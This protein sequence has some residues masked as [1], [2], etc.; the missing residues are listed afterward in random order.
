MLANKLTI[1]ASKT[2]AMVISPKMEKSMFDYFIKCGESL[3]S[4]QQNVNYLGVNIDDKLN[5]REHIKTVERKGAC[6]VGILAKSKH[7]LSQDILLQL[8]HALILTECHLIYAILVCGSTFQ[9]YID[10]LFIYQNKAVKTIDKAKWNDS[11]SPLYNELGMLKL[12]KIYELEVTKIM[13]SIDAKNIL[14]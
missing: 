4:V 5:F 2:K 11:P 7:Y 9:I 6:A 1:E 12:A 10:Q 8:Y 14:L 13:L 3:I